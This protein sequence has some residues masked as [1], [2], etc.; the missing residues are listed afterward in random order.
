MNVV[1]QAGKTSIIAESQYKNIDIES[2]V[3]EYIHSMKEV[4]EWCDIIICRGG[5]IT[6]SNNGFGIPAIIVPY[7]YASDNHQM[8]NSR[9]LESK[10]AAIVID[11][12]V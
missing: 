11:Q 10:D 3:K 7:P 6:I 5:A 1:H 4:Y 12:K 2:D 9:Y 8:K